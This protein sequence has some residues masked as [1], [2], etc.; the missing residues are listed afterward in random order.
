VPNGRSSQQVLAA[1]AECEAFLRVP[2]TPV[3]PAKQALA[4]HLVDVTPIEAFQE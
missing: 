2:A 4:D 1:V 3:L